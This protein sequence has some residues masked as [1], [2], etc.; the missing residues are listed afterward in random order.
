ME[1]LFINKVYMYVQLSTLSV[2]HTTIIHT[3]TRS[4]PLLLP[5]LVAVALTEDVLEFLYPF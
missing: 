4:L 1:D 5:L 3:R 2:T